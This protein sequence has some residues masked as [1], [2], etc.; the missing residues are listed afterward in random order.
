MTLYNNREK[1]TIKLKP[2]GAA[3]LDKESLFSQHMVYHA[4]IGVKTKTVYMIN[5]KVY[6]ITILSINDNIVSILICAIFFNTS[7]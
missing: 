4:T 3:I 1:D 5:Q 7:L 2:I 6:M